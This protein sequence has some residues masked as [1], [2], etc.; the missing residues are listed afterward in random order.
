MPITVYKIARLRWTDRKG[1]TQF[2]QGGAHIFAERLETLRCPATLE[3]L[4]GTK[5]GGIRRTDGSQSNKRLKWA[6]WYDKE[7]II[8]HTEPTRHE[9]ERDRVLGLMAARQAEFERDK[10]HG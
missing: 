1:V 7:A 10:I 2:R 8:S 6:W 5:V 3:L 9:I 4:D